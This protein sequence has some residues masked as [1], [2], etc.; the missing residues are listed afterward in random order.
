MSEIS[1]LRETKLLRL[2]EDFAANIGDRS[3]GEIHHALLLR[4]GVEDW[5]S[6]SEEAWWE[7][8]KTTFGGQDHRR[9][10][11]HNM[12]FA[13]GGG[14]VPLLECFFGTVEDRVWKNCLDLIVRAGQGMREG[15][16][17]PS[18]HGIPDQWIPSLYFLKWGNPAAVD[19]DIATCSFRLDG[20]KQ[21][22]SP[23][24]TRQAFDD[25]LAGRSTAPQG[26][27]FLILSD[28]IRVCSRDAIDFWRWTETKR[29]KGNGGADLAP[30][31]P[32]IEGAATAVDATQL[33][34]TPSSF[35]ELPEW[36]RQVRELLRGQEGCAIGD[37][38]IGHAVREHFLA[39]LERLCPGWPELYQRFQPDKFQ[40][41][42]ELVA[43]M[44]SVEHSLQA[45]KTQAE[46]EDEKGP[47]GFI[48]PLPK[49]PEWLFV[50]RGEVYEIVGLGERNSLKWMAGLGYIEKL[51][52]RPGEAIEF[53]ELVADDAP[54][55][56]TE[57]AEQTAD[58][59]LGLDQWSDQP[60][61]DQQAFREYH[62]RLNEIEA[63]LENARQSNDSGRQE[64]L[65]R[66]K[67]E[68]LAAVQAAKGLGNNT[69]NLNTD[70]DKLR[71]R[72]SMAIGRACKKLAD[73]QAPKLAQH[74]KESI[75]A[76]GG[77]FKYAP[78]LTTP[79][80]SFDQE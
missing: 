63:E 4:V 32:V 48:P 45:A 7:D 24:N 61:L 76:E 39:H 52:H 49:P 29:G 62:E 9:L 10:L 30:R 67:E 36:I 25:W 69:R 54:E 68:I 55:C 59:S 13:W 16:L 11:W 34:P 64:W 47:M 66:E 6:E 2:Q 77:A 79:Q 44:A 35:A 70:A 72:I 14:R 12:T 19:Y 58:E 57:A 27:H 23:F 22:E 42:R 37:R 43:M 41:S 18:Y 21:P 8:L 51:L 78:K 71:S 56:A 60:A 73:N 50:C 26:R 1:S 40:M 80:W 5:R 15:W 17:A 53:A 38:G 75:S 20:M 65:E 3:T 74:F 28:D 46:A 33:P 31:Q